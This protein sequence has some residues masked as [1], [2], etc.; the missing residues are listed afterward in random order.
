MKRLPMIAVVAAVLAAFAAP[1]KGQWFLSGDEEWDQHF[2]KRWTKGN[3]LY[4]RGYFKG[5]AAEWCWC[6]DNL[7]NSY[8]D[9]ERNPT[10][11]LVGNLHLISTFYPKIKP[12]L[13]KRRDAAQEKIEK[14]K[15]TEFV[16]HE[17]SE[18]NKALGDWYL[19]LEVYDDLKKMKSK[20]KRRKMR[21]RLFLFVEESLIEEKR[22]EDF[23]AGAKHGPANL[24]ARRKTLDDAF[25]QF[26]GIDDKL[27]VKAKMNLCRSAARYYEAMLATGRDGD[28]ARLVDEFLEYHKTT[29]SY[30]AF[31]RHA[32]VA[33]S[34]STARELIRRAETDLTRLQYEKV[35]REEKYIDKKD[36]KK[37]K[38]KKRKKKKKGGKKK[39]GT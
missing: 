23:L 18:F 1:A 28:A 6:L 8:P 17:F 34:Y 3:E 39:K 7:T 24:I 2:R 19:T 26:S 38:K 14:G 30:R 37:K 29:E 5:A 21:Q 10:S 11:T 31:I 9:F 4:G 13:E 20:K 25:G 15:A 16:A 36:K 22:Y 12:V 32:V 27:K 33:K 35:K